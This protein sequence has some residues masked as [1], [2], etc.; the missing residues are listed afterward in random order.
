MS[1]IDF[2]SLYKRFGNFFKIEAKSLGKAYELGAEINNSINEKTTI[3]YNGK[4]YSFKDYGGSNESKL[5]HDVLLRFLGKRFFLALKDKGYKFRKRY[6]AYKDEDE[7]NQPHKDIFRI[8]RGFVYRIIISENDFFLCIDPRV[9]LESVSSIADLTQMGLSP[10]NLN[11]FSVRYVGDE[12]YRI[13]GYL[14]ETATGKELAQ[15]SK[16]NYFCRINRYRKEKEEPEEEVVPAEK[17]FPESRPELIQTLL[18]R[19][20]IG[21][22]IIRLIRSLSFLDSPTPFTDRFVQTMKRIEEFIASAMFPLK[23]GGFSFELDRQP[24][25]IK[26]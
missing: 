4:Y 26:L 21:F 15:E 20:G 13:D 5:T 17:V 22:D 2:M 16:S 23:F 6:C 8:F 18:E 10:S 25:I 12:G 24:V 19:L 14:L 7:V 3:F 11:D 9:I 1:S